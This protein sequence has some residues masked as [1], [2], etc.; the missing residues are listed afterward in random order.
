MQKMLGK[1][2]KKYDAYRAKCDQVWLLMVAAGSGPASFIELADE[3]REHV[4]NSPFDRVLF[5]NALS[6]TVDEL[7]VLS[8]ETL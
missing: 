5:M 7:K 1:K 3:T 4:F 6:R 8:D 2:Q